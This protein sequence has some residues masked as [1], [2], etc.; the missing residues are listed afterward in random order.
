M[1]VT[2]E[3]T[4]LPTISENASKTEKTPENG[5]RGRARVGQEQVKVHEITMMKN[6]RLKKKKPVEYINIG[7]GAN[8]R[9]VQPRDELLQRGSESRSLDSE[10]P[11]S[12]TEIDCE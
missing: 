2:D 9:T 4:N 8:L 11:S 1:C 7:R 12:K 3:R 5:G 6:G 10:K